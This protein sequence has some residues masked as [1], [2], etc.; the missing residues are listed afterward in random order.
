MHFSLYNAVTD[1]SASLSLRAGLVGAVV[2][3][4]GN[5]AILWLKA[6]GTQGCFRFV[7]SLA[8]DTRTGSAP[9]HLGG[10]SLFL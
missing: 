3:S 10:K 6:P 9:R 7:F 1:W 4:V 5:H 8:R 2:K